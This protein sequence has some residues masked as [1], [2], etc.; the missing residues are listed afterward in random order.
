MRGIPRLESSSRGSPQVVSAI[1]KVMEFSRLMISVLRFKS[2][3]SRS[4]R[5]VVPLFYLF[6]VEDLTSCSPV[7]G[8]GA[9]CNCA[10][11]VSES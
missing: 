4:T 5:F 11:N 3:V 8:N 6:P 10:G 9:I 1:N 7:E 2:Y